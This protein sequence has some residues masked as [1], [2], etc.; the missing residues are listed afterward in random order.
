MQEIYQGINYAPVGLGRKL[1]RLLLERRVV[2]L[3]R[4][5]EPR[6]GNGR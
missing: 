6:L 3:S 1:N 2:V 5:E 4:K